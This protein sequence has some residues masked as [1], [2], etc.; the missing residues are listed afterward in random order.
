M[1][2][3]NTKKLQNST[4]NSSLL[5]HTV[6]LSTAVVAVDTNVTNASLNKSMFTMCNA[7]LTRE[8]EL[9]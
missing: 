8:R 5:V 4:K 2:H 6:E 7:A 9:Y 3:K 1:S